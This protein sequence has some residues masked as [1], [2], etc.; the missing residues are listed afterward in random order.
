MAGVRVQPWKSETFKISTDPELIAK[1]ADVVGLY[2]APPENAIVLHVEQSQIQ[3]L[4]RSAPMLPVRTGDAEKRTH[5]YKRHGTTTLGAALEVATGPVTGAV[6]PKH[7]W[8]KFLAFLRQL[9][10]AYPERDLYLVMDN[11]ATHKTP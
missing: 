6:K 7:R 9:D 10:R 11:C 5:D 2:L 8:Q 3:G 1:V 4:D